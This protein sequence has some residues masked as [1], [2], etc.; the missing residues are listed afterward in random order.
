M[1]RQCSMIVGYLMPHRCPNGA[2]GTCVRCR[3]DFCEEHLSLEPAGL[4][5]GACLKGSGIPA[6]HPE[7]LQSYSASDLALFTVADAVSD[8][9]TEMF[10]DVS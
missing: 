10:S 7:V 1:S 9:D 4:V 8:D 5:C 6:V 2:L 3:H